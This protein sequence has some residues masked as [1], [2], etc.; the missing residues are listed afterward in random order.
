MTNISSEL[1]WRSKFYSLLFRIVINTL[2]FFF[3]MLRKLLGERKRRLEEAVESSRRLESAAYN[4]AR[5]VLGKDPPAPTENFEEWR[6]RRHQPISEEK[7][8]KMRQKYGIV[9]SRSASVEDVDDESRPVQHRE[10]SLPPSKCVGRPQYQPPTSN[11]RRRGFFDCFRCFERVENEEPKEVAS[12]H[13]PRHPVSVDSGRRQIAPD[14]SSVCGAKE[15]RRKREKSSRRE[16]LIER[17]YSQWFILL[18]NED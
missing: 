7:L 18:K 6:K 5:T 11:L 10:K 12:H 17:G 8:E 14:W 15:I 16:A 1:Y 9:Q 13:R 3:K 4:Y 2:D